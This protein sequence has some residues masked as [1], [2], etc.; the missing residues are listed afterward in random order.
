MF[1]IS[2]KDVFNSLIFKHTEERE[3]EMERRS[4]LVS[5]S[6]QAEAPGPPVTSEEQQSKPVQEWE[7]CKECDGIH[8]LRRG[9]SPTGLTQVDLWLARKLV[10]M[11]PSGNLYL[12]SL[13]SNTWGKSLDESTKTTPR[14]EVTLD[15]KT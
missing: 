7:P 6:N 10:W 3:R 8:L 2:F 4:C 9:R 11:L 13:L 12:I 15:K 14:E 1:S 5:Q